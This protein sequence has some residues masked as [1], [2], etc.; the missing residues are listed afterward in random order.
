[1]VP[2]RVDLGTAPITVSSFW[3]PLKI[4][5]VGMERMPYSVAMLGDSSVLSF[6]CFHAGGGAG[7]EDGR[8]RS[9]R[10][11]K[12]VIGR[13]R[14]D[15]GGFSAS[16]RLARRA[17]DG[18]RAGVPEEVTSLGNARGESTTT[19]RGWERLG[20]GGRRGVVGDCTYRLELPRVLLSELVDEGSDHAARPA[21]GRPEVNE[22]GNVALEHLSL[23]GSVGHDGGGACE[24]TIG[25]RVRRR[26]PEGASRTDADAI[27][28]S[29][30]VNG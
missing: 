15:K 12:R 21:P 20:S 9:P 18:G 11:N 16:P 30:N 13:S 5:T 24:M 4:I 10:R 26:T 3:P 7:S 22:D 29:A 25:A 27:S 17:R 19:R 2:V 23:E 28:S 6:T 14:A 1:M 8:A